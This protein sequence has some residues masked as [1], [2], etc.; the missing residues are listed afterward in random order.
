M[1]ADPLAARR[2]AARRV[3]LPLDPDEPGGGQLVCIVHVVPEWEALVDQAPP[4]AEQAAL[5]W[6]WDVRTLRPLAL[7]AAVE[8]EGYGRLTPQ[9][10]AEHVAARHVSPGEADG[11]LEHVLA[12]NARSTVVSLGKESG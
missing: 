5:G 9:Q 4:T 1:S 8:L 6:A 7:A 12:L 11:L 10:W 3:A 2:V